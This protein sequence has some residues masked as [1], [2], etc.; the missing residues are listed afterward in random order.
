MT[1]TQF[2]GASEW[3]SEPDQMM[4]D[5]T[6]R[7]LAWLRRLHESDGDDVEDVAA[8]IGLGLRELTDAHTVVVF[9]RDVPDDALRL[10]AI[11]Q[12]EDAP[13]LDE[14]FE[15]EVAQASADK[16]DPAAFGSAR[17]PA[18]PLWSSLPTDAF[19]VANA[20]AHLQVF[21][22]EACD[23]LDGFSL[24]ERADDTLAPADEEEGALPPS[25][26]LPLRSHSR[27]GHGDIIGLALL[28]IFTE[29]GLLSS[30][31]QP[32]VA[33]AATHA[34]DAMVAALRIERLGHSYRQL[35]ELIAKVS[36]ARQPQ[37][38][39]HAQSVGYYAG[40]IAQEL[41]LTAA[42]RERVEFAG[43]LHD[44]GKAGVPEAILHKQDALTE[45]ELE[46][47]RGST[48]SGAEWLNEVEGL[49]EVALMVRHQ[50][51]RWDGTGVPDGLT[52]EA[53][54]LGARI[55]AVAL[56]F[57]AMTQPRADRGPRPVLLAFTQA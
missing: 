45:E 34:A 9:A 55:L 37:R 49:Q 17:F 10:L 54:P 36:D 11:S 18:A 46:L 23:W 30:N 44:V 56:R 24:G 41:G 31:L 22:G 28:W 3:R 48:I 38:A 16:F 29:D 47:V 2:F 4:S 13:P 40:L 35:A 8:R 42:E 51:E 39:G 27:V 32:L 6:R 15:E 26:A 7:L 25:L 20:P 33:A 43:L 52:G 53:I 12:Q 5:S 14:G 21:I 19:W 50:N 57:A 1:T